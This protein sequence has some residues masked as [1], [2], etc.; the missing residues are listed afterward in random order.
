MLYQA[1]NRPGDDWAPLDECINEPRNLRFWKDFPRDDD[2]AVIAEGGSGPLG[3]AWIRRFTDDELSPIDDP[4]T[5]VLAIGV[6]E[7]QRGN[8]VGTRLVTE[9]LRLASDR[10]VTRI[11]LTTGLFNTAAVRLYERHGFKE[12]FRQGDGVQMRLDID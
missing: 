6:V 4:D 2:V 11:S 5:P 8:G 9:L 1:A 3:A 12:V 7:E 10:G